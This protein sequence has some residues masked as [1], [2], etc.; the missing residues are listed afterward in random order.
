MSRRYLIE[1]RTQGAYLGI[2]ID[3]KSG[4]EARLFRAADPRT[5]ALFFVSQLA[6]QDELD[7]ISASPALYRIV[8]VTT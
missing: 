3:P 5:P 6:A 8:A 2:G 1:H 4:G 7:Q